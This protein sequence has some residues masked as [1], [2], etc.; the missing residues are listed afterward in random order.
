[1]SSNQEVGKRVLISQKN[2]FLMF[3][4]Y[5]QDEDVAD[6]AQPTV[7]FCRF[8]RRTESDVFYIV[9]MCVGQSVYALL[10]Q[11]KYG[12]PNAVYFKHLIRLYMQTQRIVRIHIGANISE[13]GTVDYIA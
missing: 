4:V 13:F 9:G 3:V 5:E 1:M 12:Y 6:V 8:F 10:Y 11:A 2:V 7:L